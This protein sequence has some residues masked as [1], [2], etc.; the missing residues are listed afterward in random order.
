LY[1]SCCRFNPDC[2][3][4]TAVTTPGQGDKCLYSSSALSIKMRQNTQIL[5]IIYLFA[6]EITTQIK[7]KIQRSAIHIFTT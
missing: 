5:K 2:L 4:I 1:S 7:R 3:T 6:N